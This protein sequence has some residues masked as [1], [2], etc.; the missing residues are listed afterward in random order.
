M[1]E[2]KLYNDIHLYS[3]SLSKTKSATSH[4]SGKNITLS[5]TI[6]P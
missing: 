4:L 2:D 1:E 3:E 5:K 6:S